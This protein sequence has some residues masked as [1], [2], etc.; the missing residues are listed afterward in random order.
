M[1][2]KK[3]PK[4]K[5]RKSNTIATRLKG[6]PTP[7]KAEKE[8]WKGLV[9]KLTELVVGNERRH[10]LGAGVLHYRAL[11]PDTFKIPEGWPK[12]FDIERFDGYMH[13]TFNAE[14]LL[15][16]LYE[17]KLADYSANQLYVVRGNTMKSDTWGDGILKLLNDENF[18]LL[19][20]ID[21]EQEYDSSIRI[22]EEE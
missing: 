6:I 7:S 15:G 1:P 9:D 16:W 8:K 4:Q 11:V 17:R 5:P 13:C 22:D 19:L 10:D 2:L 18:G 3:K 21:G 14:K 12:P 20:D